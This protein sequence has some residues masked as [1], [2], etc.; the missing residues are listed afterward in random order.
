M[1]EP[2]QKTYIQQMSEDMQKI[3]EA[4]ELLTRYGIS[5]ELMIMYIQQKTKL[6]KGVINSVLD[7]QKEFL[8]EA[9]KPIP[10]KK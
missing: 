4:M 2:E 1:A 10:E 6:G 5:K 8:N 7:F 3:K 9:F